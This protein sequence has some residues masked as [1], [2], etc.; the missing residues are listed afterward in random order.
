MHNANSGTGGVEKK[1]FVFSITVRSFE[2]ASPIVMF[3]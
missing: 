3:L 2:V 1:I